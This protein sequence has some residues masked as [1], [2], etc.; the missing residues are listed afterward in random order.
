MKP[1]G[2][3]LSLWLSHLPLCFV[4]SLSFSL[5]YLAPFPLSSSLLPFPLFATLHVHAHTHTHIFSSLLLPSVFCLCSLAQCS[6]HGSGW[7][8]NRRALL[9]HRAWHWLWS[10]VTHIQAHKKMCTYPRDMHVQVLK[11]QTRKRNSAR[12]TNM[13]VSTDTYVQT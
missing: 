4:C 5:P 13:H 10:S 3:P 2:G 7:G 8:L 6:R 11:L 9:W 12:N 1:C